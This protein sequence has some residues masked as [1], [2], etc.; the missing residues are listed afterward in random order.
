MSEN[1]D[2]TDRLLAHYQS[3]GLLARIEAG[4]AALGED[5]AA[6]THDALAR[7]DEFHL[8]GA[9]ATEALI[10]RLDPAPGAR[11]LDVGAGLGGPARR[12]AAARNV[13]VTGIDLSPEYCETAAAL[14]AR[15]GLSDRVR[16]APVPVENLADETPGFDAAWTLHVGMNVADKEAFYAAIWRCLRPGGRFLVYDILAGPA[17]APAYPMPWAATVEESFLSTADS[18][19]IDLQMAGF[20]VTEQLDETEAARAFMHGAVAR[21]RAAAAPAPLGLHTVLGPVFREIAHNLLAGL[22][23]GAIELGLFDCEK[24]M[25]EDRPV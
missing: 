22:E 20:T 8:R 6:P 15:V 14:T 19:V 12:L 25:A 1:R 7:V 16:F 10:A 17:A 11:V 23:G 24:P 4:L 21:A 13:E 18:L 2:I 5:P 9:A 3:P